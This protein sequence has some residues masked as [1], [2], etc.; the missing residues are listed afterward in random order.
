MTAG[1]VLW[2]WCQLE[3]VATEISNNIR[4]RDNDEVL[5]ESIQIVLKSTL[6][7]KALGSSLRSLTVRVSVLK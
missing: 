5:P 7:D 4:A 6:N 3:K 2:S 1:K